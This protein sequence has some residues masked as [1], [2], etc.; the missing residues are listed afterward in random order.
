MPRLGLGS[1]LTGGVV[2]PF[3]NTG[4]LVLDGT[5]DHVTVT[6]H[7]DWDFGTGDFTAAFWISCGAQSDAYPSILA[8]ATGSYAS[9]AV[10]IRLGPNSG[11]TA[12]TLLQLYVQAGG[13]GSAMLTSTTTMTDDAWRHV[14]VIRA[15]AVFYLYIDGSQEDTY[16][17]NNPDVDFADNGTFY[18]GK[19]GWD[20]TNGD[21]DGYLDEVAMYSKALSSSERSKLI[22]DGTPETAGNAKDISDLVGYWRLEEG[23]GT[24]AYDSSGNSHTGTLVNATFGE[25]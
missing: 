23:T 9:G 13:G 4:Y 8:S 14:M 18:I 12:K 19:N 20:G 15:S 25:H 11:G 24:S 22:G 3:T 2:L 21:L 10:V 6:D 5:N 17:T 7:D 1:S 16:D